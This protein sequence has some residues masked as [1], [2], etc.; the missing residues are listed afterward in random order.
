MA[1]ITY[2]L[3]PFQRDEQPIKV[4][5]EE[6]GRQITKQMLRSLN[7]SP[8]VLKKSLA[9]LPYLSNLKVSEDSLAVIYP[10]KTL[11]SSLA[12]LL[13]RI[14]SRASPKNQALFDEKRFIRN[15]TKI[16]KRLLPAKW[17]GLV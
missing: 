11:G 13:T 8:I 17:G 1:M 6:Q 15:L 10:D 5:S 4:D 7:I 14:F 2:K 9:I 12:S 16:P 3:T